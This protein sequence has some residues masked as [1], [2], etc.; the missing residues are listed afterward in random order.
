MQQQQEE[1]GKESRGLQQQQLQIRNDETL[2]MD[3]QQIQ[4]LRQGLKQATCQHVHQFQHR[5]DAIAVRCF[6]TEKDVQIQ[7]LSQQLAASEQVATELRQNLQWREQKFQELQEEIQHLQLKLRE[8]TAKRDELLRKP[9]TLQKRKISLNWIPCKAAPHKMRRGSA[10]VCSNMAYFRPAPSNQVVS[11]NLDTE[12]WF[13]LTE[14]PREWFTLA[15][16][17][18]LLTAVGGMKPG[19]YTNTLLS[20]VEKGRKKTWVE[21][22]PPMP[23]KRALTAVICSG[24][25]LVVA[26]SWG[27]GGTPLNTVEVMDTDTLKRS[28]GT[29]LPHSL[30]DASATVCG[31]SVYV[32]GGHDQHD[33]TEVL[34]C[35]LSSLCQSLTPRG[36]EMIN[37][38][39]DRNHPV[40]YTI[41]DLPVKYSTCVTVNGQLLAVGGQHLYN[42]VTNNIYTYDT[43]TNSWEVI[44]NMPTPRRLCLVVVFPGNKLI[45]VGGKT[46]ATVTDKVEIGSID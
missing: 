15:V 33:A 24:N 35:S 29:S 28:T 16:V 36:A 12:E 40:W 20:L 3:R 45:V 26:G 32:V 21:H 14:C 6:V 46:D 4:Q 17:S 22:F 9:V 2:Q 30:S 38:P 7:E 37:L 39:L 44:S 41:A 23:T 31:D 5:D 42:K 43:E 8:N 1:C 13:T 18:G 19:N 11:C 27:E 10:A 25:A 34:T